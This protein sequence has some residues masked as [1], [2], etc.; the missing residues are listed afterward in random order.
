MRERSSPAP[1]IKI[2]VF[3]IALGFIVLVQSSGIDK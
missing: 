2:L 1:E 3:I